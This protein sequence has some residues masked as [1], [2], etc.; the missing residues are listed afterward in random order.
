MLQSHLTIKINMSYCMLLFTN[1]CENLLL[2]FQLLA[3]VFAFVIC[4]QTGDKNHAV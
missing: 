3:V 2:F 4:C 1:A